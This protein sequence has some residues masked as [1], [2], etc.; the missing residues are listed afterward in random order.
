[1]AFL[2]LPVSLP[3]CLPWSQVSLVLT[4]S[5][6]DA[7]AEPTPGSPLAPS[8]LNSPCFTLILYSSHPSVSSRGTGSQ[9]LAVFQTPRMLSSFMWNSIAPPALAMCKFCI[10]WLNQLWIPSMVGWISG[11]GTRGCR[12]QTVS[13]FP[14]FLTDALCIFAF[15]LPRQL[16]SKQ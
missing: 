3:T 5:H 13:L 14:G 9:I 4:A 8:S 2:P 7:Q 16:W 12:G 1:M 15:L 11:C 6:V 10:H